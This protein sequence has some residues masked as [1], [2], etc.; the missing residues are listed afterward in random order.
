M[1]RAQCSGNVARGLFRSA[2]LK[3]GSLAD[4]A[5]ALGAGDGVEDF[6]AHPVGEIAEF[7]IVREVVE[8]QHRQQRFARLWHLLA[9]RYD[10]QIQIAFAADE[11]LDLIDEGLPGGIGGIALPV[12]QVGG[13]GQF[14]HD[15]A[16]ARLDHYRDQ[17]VR[18][19]RQRG[20]G[21]DPA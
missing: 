16:V 9:S 13:L 6:L 11:V 20:F 18:A 8:S 4:H 7:R 21:T 15:R 3:A 10:R 5:Q 17:R 1:G 14:E 19:V 2:E 12:D